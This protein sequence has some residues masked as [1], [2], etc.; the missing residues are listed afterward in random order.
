VRANSATNG[1]AQ[2]YTPYSLSFIDNLSWT[3]GDHSFK[4]GGEVRAIRM[5]TDRV[6]GTTYTWASINNFLTN[7]LQSTQFLGNVSAPSPFF[8]GSSGQPQARQT[9][10]IGYAQDEWKIKSN[11]TL[12]YGLRYEYYTPL[13]EKD[14]RQILFDVVT[15][16]LRD[17]AGDPLISSKTNFGPRVAMTWSPNP[18]ATGFFGGGRTILRGGFGIYYGP[19]Q[20]EDQIQPIESNRISSTVSGGSFRKTRTRSSR[21]LSTTRITVH[22]SRVRTRPTIRFRKRFI[23]TPS[24]FSRSCRTKWLSPARL[25]V[26]RDATC[27]LRRRGQPDSSGT[28]HDC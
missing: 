3:R 10:Y 2:P 19:G 12:S 17:P 27:F 8:N 23:S 15:G 26:R 4:F 18:K 24:Q 14:N 7:A 28:D 1:R 25:L 22:I 11:L 13:R 20:T 5:W 9:Y 6:G 16:V 21:T